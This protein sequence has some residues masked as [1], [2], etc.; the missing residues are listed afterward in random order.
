MKT[1]SK[2]EINTLIQAG[3]TGNYYLVIHSED[4][5]K[6]SH[7][8]AYNAIAGNV[9]GLDLLS[10]AWKNAVNNHLIKVFSNYLKQEKIHIIKSR[11]EDA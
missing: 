4:L 9:K 11:E 8:I 1:Y 10:D 2:E 7:A 3:E 6:F 5:I